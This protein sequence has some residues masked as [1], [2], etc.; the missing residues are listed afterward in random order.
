MA[1]QLNVD[2]ASKTIDQQP[3][4]TVQRR[5]TVRRARSDSAGAM[6]ELE[7]GCGAEEVVLEEFASHAARDDPGPYAL[8]VMKGSYP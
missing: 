3:S 8:E 2:R 5:L 4:R 1:R 6:V 7:G